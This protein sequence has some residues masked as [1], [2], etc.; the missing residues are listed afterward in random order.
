VGEARFP[1]EIGHHLRCGGV[2]RLHDVRK[3]CMEIESG[4]LDILDD[5]TGR[6]T[7]SVMDINVVQ[8]ILEGLQVKI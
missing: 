3:W 8:L 4:G 2:M 6:L 5:C 1:I 7:R